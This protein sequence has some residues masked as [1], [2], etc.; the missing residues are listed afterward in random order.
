MAFKE[1]RHD[2]LRLFDRSNE[3]IRFLF[4]RKGILKVY[5]RGKLETQTRVIRRPGLSTDKRVSRLFAID[6]FEMSH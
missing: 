6:L 1:W 5:T 2:E 4:F 3:R